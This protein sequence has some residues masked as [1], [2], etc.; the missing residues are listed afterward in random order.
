VRF[1]PHSVCTCSRYAA[2]RSI[3]SSPLP[4]RTRWRRASSCSKWVLIPG[5][6][7]CCMH[8][9][10]W[11]TV[12]RSCAWYQ[13][14]TIRLT[15]AM[16]KVLRPAGAA[17][18]YG[19]INCDQAGT[20]NAPRVLYVIVSGGPQVRA[21]VERRSKRSEMVKSE[22][23]APWLS[24][25]TT[26]SCFPRARSLYLG[27]SSFDLE[28][29]LS[30]HVRASNP[31]WTTVGSYIHAKRGRLGMPSALPAVKFLL[32]HGQSMFDSL[33]LSERMVSQPA[34]GLE[35]SSWRVL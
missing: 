28:R 35:M 3:L 32:G 21:E 31:S 1:D 34:T 22:W 9:S 26:S 27:F 16:S 8:C 6:Q 33:F 12:L 19:N 23:R 20:A 2:L 5:I 7:T 10:A 11:R 30:A 4:S 18:R 13:S 14:S 15:T 29:R 24:S 17:V 25:T